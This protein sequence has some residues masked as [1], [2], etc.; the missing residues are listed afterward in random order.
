MYQYDTYMADVVPFQRPIHWDNLRADEAERL[1]HE[2]S[3]TTSNVNFTDHA[4]DRVDLRDISQVDAYEI[5][6]SGHVTEA[7]IKN[8]HNEWEVKICKRPRGNR[9]AVV[10]TI[11]VEETEELT[12]ITVMWKD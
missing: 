6:R 1:I 11:V 5:L 3:V 10:I 9:E 2:R 8:E 7:P 4:F 12:I